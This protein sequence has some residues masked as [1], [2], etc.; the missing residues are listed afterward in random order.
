MGLGFH[1]LTALTTFTN[2][3][4]KYLQTITPFN[5]LWSGC[6]HFLSLEVWIFFLRNYGAQR[7]PLICVSLVVGKTG[8]WLDRWLSL[9]EANDSPPTSPLACSTW[10]PS[11]A[12]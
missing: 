4:S 2:C 5:I 9:A 8:T 1:T 7:I 3:P 12:S 10:Q 6:C 11:W